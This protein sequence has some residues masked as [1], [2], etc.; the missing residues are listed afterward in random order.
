MEGQ[1]FEQVI[2]IGLSMCIILFFVYEED[3]KK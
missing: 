1:F 2:L 3:T